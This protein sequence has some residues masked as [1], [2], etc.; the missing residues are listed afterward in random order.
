VVVNG[1][2]PFWVIGNEG[3][4]FPSVHGPV[5]QVLLGPAER[6]D[7]I[8]DFSSLQPGEAAGYHAT[9][10]AHYMLEHAHIVYVQGIRVT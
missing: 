8:F 7:I 6:Y 9:S 10:G 4:F 5:D 2:I 1:I 3:G